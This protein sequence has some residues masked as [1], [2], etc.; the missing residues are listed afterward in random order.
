[1][2]NWITAYSTRSSKSGS[3]K[4]PGAE[5]TVVVHY[6]GTL[7][8]GT[9]FDSSYNRGEPATFRVNEVIEGWQLTLSQMQEGDKWQI[10][11]PPELSLWRSAV[12][13]Q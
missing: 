2:N 9:E 6:R 7:I 4:Q 11:I 5:D 10:V 1:L 13:A 12:Q 8:D 3:G